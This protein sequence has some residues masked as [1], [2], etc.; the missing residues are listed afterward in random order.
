MGELA[1]G[2]WSPAAGCGPPVLCSPSCSILLGRG[3]LPMAGDSSGSGQTYKGSLRGHPLGLAVSTPGSQPSLGRKSLRKEVTQ[4]SL[5]TS[6]ELFGWELQGPGNPEWSLKGG[7]VGG[8]WRAY[9][10]AL[11]S[12]TPRS[13]AWPEPASQS[14]SPGHE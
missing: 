8:S 11:R 12:P 10:L 7:G 13:G 9:P 6:P 5:D 14:M 1:L 3:P 2:P 4:A